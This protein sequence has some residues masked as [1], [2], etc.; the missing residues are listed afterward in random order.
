MK[1][2]PNALLIFSL[3][4]ITLCCSTLLADEKRSIPAGDLPDF[5]KGMFTDPYE[6]MFDQEAKNPLSIGK[7]K[8]GMYLGGING[9]LFYWSL[10]DCARKY[11]NMPKAR[12]WGSLEGLETMSNL[13]VSL[14]EVYKIRHVNPAFVRWMYVNL[15]PEPTDKIHNVTCQE[16]YDRVLKR[17]FRLMTAAKL[18]LVNNGLEEKAQLD[19]LKAMR[20][21]SFE[22][23]SYL[24]KTYGSALPTFTKEFPAAGQ[25]PGMA[26]GFWIRRSIDGTAPDLWEGLA[27]V[28]ELYDDDWFQSV[29][30]KGKG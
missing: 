26:I 25:T 19:L 7:A 23:L 27:T 20:D 16:I 12:S 14:R 29:Q 21:Q 6:Y 15:I 2:K 18:Y 8:L 4:L 17:F 5:Y 11:S 28:M 10:T 3:I 1:S 22:A 24:E 13:Q 9:I 30:P